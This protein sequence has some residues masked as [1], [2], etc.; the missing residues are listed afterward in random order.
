MLGRGLRGPKM[1]G[2]PKC[3]VVDFTYRFVDPENAVIHQ[4]VVGGRS[5][6]PDGE[7]EE[8]EVEVPAPVRVNRVIAARSSSSRGDRVQVVGR[9]RGDLSDMEGARLQATHR[10]RTVTATVRRGLVRIT[11]VAGLGFRSLSGA[12]RHLTG[13]Q[14]NGN[15]FWSVK[16][17]SS[18]VTVIF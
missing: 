10:G 12:A 1:Q 15:R 4:Q 7:D 11:G 14:T 5:R 9:G 18:Q 2:T 13:H 8:E 3:A 6:T 17:P 16:R